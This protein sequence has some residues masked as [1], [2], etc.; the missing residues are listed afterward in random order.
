MFAYLVFN[1][2]NSFE[3]N[4]MHGLVTGSKLQLEVSSFQDSCDYHVLCLFPMVEDQDVSS[5][6]RLKYCD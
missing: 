2:L 5:R 6:V 3:R 1:W 4:R